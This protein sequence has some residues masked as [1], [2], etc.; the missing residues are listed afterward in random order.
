M[1]AAAVPGSVRR[2]P[3]SWRETSA[4]DERDDTPRAAVVLEAQCGRTDAVEVLDDDG[5][6][7][8]PVGDAVHACSADPGRTG[9]TWAA[10]ECEAAACQQRL[11]DLGREP[12][13]EL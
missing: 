10:S 4:E 8:G 12:L 13:H 1:T 5:R 7:D 2:P 11:V 6:L 3:S 9:G